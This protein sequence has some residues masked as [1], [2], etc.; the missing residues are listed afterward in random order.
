MITYVCVCERVCVRE[1]ERTGGGERESDLIFLHRSSPPFASH[2]PIITYLCVC[3]RESVCVR[4][5]ERRKG[6]EMER[7]DL[8]A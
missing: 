2:W 7:D 3:E 5:R 6:R 1:K 4:E 8:F